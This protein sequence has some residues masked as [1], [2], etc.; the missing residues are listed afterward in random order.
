MPFLLFEITYLIGFQ[1]NTYKSVG[2]KM[3]PGYYIPTMSRRHV[4]VFSL[5]CWTLSKH[6]HAF[7]EKKI[8]R[9][10][11]EIS[12]EMNRFQYAE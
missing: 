6:N 7:D 10:L 9:I 12:I 1:R 5:T 3:L 4:Q 11:F 2:S 8:H